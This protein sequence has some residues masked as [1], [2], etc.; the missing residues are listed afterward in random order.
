[1]IVVELAAGAGHY[2]AS[3]RN[4]VDS[5]SWGSWGSSFRF[6]IPEREAGAHGTL[7]SGNERAYPAAMLSGT[8]SGQ[9]ECP[10][11]LTSARLTLKEHDGGALDGVFE[12]S[13]HP[14][15]PSVPSGSYEIHGT[16]EPA[17]SRVDLEPGNWIE[18]PTGYS[19]VGMAGR[20]PGPNG[21]LRLQLDSAACTFFVGK[22]D[23]NAP[24]AGNAATR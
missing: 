19:S 20:P 22:R 10:Q 14:S 3:S 7:A 1:M 4:G 8:W 15:N 16:Y 18:Q 24:G 21:I 23:P 17:V 9:Y 11:G 6:V 13:A 2:D 5:L 12:F